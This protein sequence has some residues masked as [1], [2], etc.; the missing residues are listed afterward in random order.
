MKNSLIEQ[1]YQTS[2]KKGKKVLYLVLKKKPSSKDMLQ[3][4]EKEVEERLKNY[5][6][7]IAPKLNALK[8]DNPE[9]SL[10]YII[11]KGLINILKSMINEHS[12]SL[13]E[14]DR[15]ILN[16]IMKEDDDKEKEKEKEKEKQNKKEKEN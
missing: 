14:E 10:K 15:S 8:L 1:I 13:S 3:K 5:L 6:I 9:E 2:V 11:L 7:E 16:D 12:I 4:L